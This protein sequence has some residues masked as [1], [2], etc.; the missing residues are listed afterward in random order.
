MVPCARPGD[1]LTILDA[2]VH[3]HS[4]DFQTL[5]R[6]A[7]SHAR[8]HLRESINVCDALVAIMLLEES[9]AVRG[10]LNVTWLLATGLP[11]NANC[12]CCSLAMLLL[13]QATAS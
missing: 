3:A 1:V 6:L 7:R 8:L 11:R 9:M 5:I 12:C 13:I 2:C 10:E 4:T